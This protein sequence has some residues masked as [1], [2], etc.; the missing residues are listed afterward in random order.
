MLKAFWRGLSRAERAKFLAAMI[1]SVL[2]LAG[3]TLIDPL[4]GATL[5]FLI[6]VV[7][8]FWG[9]AETAYTQRHRFFQVIMPVLSEKTAKKLEDDEFI[10]PYFMLVILSSV[11]PGL[12]AFLS[13]VP[14]GVWLP[15]FILAT[16]LWVPLWTLTLA[17]GAL[18]LRGF[19]QLSRYIET[20]MG[21]E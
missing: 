9:G 16:L 1:C 13:V 21:G 20:R 2:A 11:F 3:F 4:H 7:G 17:G 15:N 18:L 14:N 5:F 8:L 12:I 10:F 19:F 6:C